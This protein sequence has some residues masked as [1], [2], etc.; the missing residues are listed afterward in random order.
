MSEERRRIVLYLRTKT[1]EQADDGF[2]C[3]RCDDGLTCDRAQVA[4]LIE[5]I[6]VPAPQG[7][8]P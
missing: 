4:D 2:S 1:C 3:G 8:L 7:T 6:A 5:R